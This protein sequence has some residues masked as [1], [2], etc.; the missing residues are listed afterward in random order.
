MDPAESSQDIIWALGTLT[1][2]VHAYR[3]DIGVKAGVTV[4]GSRHRPMNILEGIDIDDPAVRDHICPDCLARLKYARFMKP[5]SELYGHQDQSIHQ[6]I[7]PD[8]HPA[9]G[10]MTDLPDLTGCKTIHY[11]ESV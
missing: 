7:H 2:Y 4:C 6:T 3:G 1:K 9:E 8:V 10:I 11:L 5:I